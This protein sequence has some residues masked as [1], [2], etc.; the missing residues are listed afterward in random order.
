MSNLSDIESH[1]PVLIVGGGI[2][3]VGI[4]RDLSLHGLPCLLI[5]KKDFASQTSGASS[6][7]LHG[8]LRYLENMDMGLVWEASREK[9]HWLTRAPHLCRERPFY[10]PVFRDSSR[11]LWKIKMGLALY[12][13]LSP[14]SRL[15]HRHVGAEATLRAVPRLRREGLRGAGVYYDAVVDDVKLALEVL[16]DALVEKS[17]EALNYV[18]LSDLE[19]ERGGGYRAFLRDELTGR[20]RMVG[21]SNVVFATGPFTD[22]LLKKLKGICWSPKL[23]PSQGSHLWILR[24][25][26]P[27]EHP[28]LLTPR[29]G[30]VIFAIPKADKVLV[31]TTETA[32]GKNFFDVRASEIEI[33]YLL[34]NIREFFPEVRI[35][36][37]DVA[38]AFAGVRPLVKG[39]SKDRDSTDR[40]HKIFR[41][42]AD[43]YVVLG[44]KYT[45]FRI[46]GREVSRSLCL[47]NGIAYNSGLS[48]NPLRRRSVVGTM[49]WGPLTVDHVR[50]ILKRER[51]RTLE[52][53]IKR[54][55]GV[56]NRS[57]WRE[58]VSFEDF[59]APLMP[60]LREGLDSASLDLSRF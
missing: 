56:H 39:D 19:R 25:S 20:E 21:A 57:F 2:V 1:Y 7:I 42:C 16:Y 34:G 8:G 37:G 22:Q 53:L 40:Q 6:K 33:D 47:K 17:G 31:G 46:M 26:L 14:S 27:L 30:R 50:S 44:G 38:G 24:E 23:L 11:P 48:M 12:D 51:V 41:P 43:A 10:L 35:G 5:D 28:V 4:F 54:R 15:R 9:R 60:E 55:L 29:D 18:E 36:R 3:G 58:S 52:D 59:F 32:P 49:P 13:A 45:T